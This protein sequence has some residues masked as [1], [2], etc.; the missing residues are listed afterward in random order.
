MS[1]FYFL[2]IFKKKEKKNYTGFG[3][4]LL[5][6]G[7]IS[8]NYDLTIFLLKFLTASLFNMVG[9]WKGICYE[10]LTVNPYLKGQHQEQLH[11]L[12]KHKLHACGKSNVKQQQEM[13]IYVTVNT[14]KYSWST[15]VYI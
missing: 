14:L 11:L 7:F 12:A 4:V 1:N 13:W 5:V 6:L 10:H 2:D 9:H 8:P 15:P 3:K